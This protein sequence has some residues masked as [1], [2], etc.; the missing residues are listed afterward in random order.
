MMRPYLPL[1]LGLAAGAA[2]GADLPV[3]QV[4]LYKHG[5]GYFERSG[6]V[7]AGESARLEFKSDEMNDVLKSLTI[8][9]KNGGKVTGLRYDSSEP[10]AKKLAEFP[11]QLGS[12]QP[13]SAV[14][15]Q[16]KGARVEL[17]LGGQTV[18]GAIVGGRLIPGD[19]KRP[20][21]EQ[22]TLL[23]DSGE[24][25]TLDLTAVAGVRFPDPKLQ[26]QFRDYLAAVTNSRAQEKRS[27][28]IDSSGSDAREVVASYML[29]TPVWKSS[30]RLI[31]D[32]GSQA[33]LEGWAIVDNTTGE[34]WTG[35]QLALVSGRPISFVSKLYEPRYVQRPVAQLPEDSAARPVVHEGGLV[36]EREDVAAN[37]VTRP[38]AAMAPPPPAPAISAPR[39]VLQSS[40][41]A[42]ASGRELG[43]LFEY[44][45]ATPVTVRKNESAML[46]FVQQKIESR[47]LV[48]YSDQG[49]EHPTNAAELTNATGKTLDGGPI[50]IFDGGAYGGEALMDTLKTGDK[51]LISY[52]V[53]LGTRIT[54]QFDSKAEVVREI[55]FRRGILT[56]RTAADETKTYTIRN[57]DRK[58]K[59]LII[60]HAA[61]PGYDLLIPKAAEKTA[62]A[63]RFEVKLPPAATEKF[64]VN[65]ER[66]YD[67]TFAISNLTP[68][69]LLSYTRNKA[70]SDTARKQLEQIV[71]LKN[72][73]ASADLDKQRA[74][75]GV[76]AI[77]RNQERLRQNIASLNNVT[78][79]QQQVQSYA[80]E[81][82]DQEGQITKLRDQSAAAQRKRDE[83]QG[84][85]NAAIAKTEF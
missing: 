67:N 31:L 42:T 30:Y 36:M 39:I 75:T 48:V 64:A 40:V 78:G 45:I 19:D 43:E 50:T 7:R 10:L 58:P 12:Q 27:L 26:A 77:V 69:L 34:D 46:P 24:L 38:M 76:D 33:T 20:Q 1:T 65:E 5:V 72:Q 71:N 51:R 23:D 2:L 80:K 3:R 44:R 49:S 11:F 13:L 85:L 28:Y 81:L 70:L 62:S 52:A 59:T 60:E 73:I 41:A 82:A 22:V 47:K 83:L 66:V 53:D 4:V 68:D 57:V 9:E 54:T 35:V 29:P 32:V 18:A 74:D 8:E 56:A 6:P 15:D 17:K 79:Q 25:R 63:Y 84:Q 21:Q 14:L 16:L 37:K 55:H 61:R